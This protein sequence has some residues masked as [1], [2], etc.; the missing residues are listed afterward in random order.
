MKTF[1]LPTQRC[2]DTLIVIPEAKY[3]FTL[4]SPKRIDLQTKLKSRLAALVGEMFP[5]LVGAEKV[6]NS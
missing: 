1:H 2:A 3:Y 6:T 5:I 4:F